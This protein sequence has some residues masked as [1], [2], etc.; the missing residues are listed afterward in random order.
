MRPIPESGV[1]FG[2]V[3]VSRLGPGRSVSA[4]P[5][6]D[7]RRNLTGDR[8]HAP[9]GTRPGNDDDHDHDDEDASG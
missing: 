6:P 3:F 5:V 4:A 8:H 2:V 9:R 1:V 7:F